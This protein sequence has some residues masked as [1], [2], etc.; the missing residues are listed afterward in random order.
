MILSFNQKIRGFLK[1]IQ[2]NIW[3]NTIIIYKIATIR[4]ILL[5]IFYDL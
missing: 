2:K 4:N 1:T 3:Y 5:K